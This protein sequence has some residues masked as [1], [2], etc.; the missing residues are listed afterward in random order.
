MADNVSIKD[1]M[2]SVDAGLMVTWFESRRLSLRSEAAGKERRLRSCFEGVG[3][4]LADVLAGM[5]G[6][7]DVANMV[8]DPELS[9][10]SRKETAGSAHGLMQGRLLAQVTG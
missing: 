8:N 1:D 3:E 6:P 5:M 9:N 4:V 10:Y 2:T 7:L